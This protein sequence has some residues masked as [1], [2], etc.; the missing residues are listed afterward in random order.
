[1]RLKVKDL[2]VRNK[3]VTLQLDDGNETKTIY[4]DILKRSDGKTYIFLDTTDGMAS[5]VYEAELTC[6]NGEEYYNLYS[7]PDDD[8]DFYEDKLFEERL[9]RYMESKKS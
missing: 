8:Y 9:Q 1:M 2:S 6:E 5:Y 3:V 7:T 4:S